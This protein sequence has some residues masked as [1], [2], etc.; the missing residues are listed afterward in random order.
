VGIGGVT[1][2]VSGSRTET[3]TTH[4]SGNFSFA[5]TA[6]GDYTIS[7]A[8]AHYSFSPP[9]T[10]SNLSGDQTADFTG[11]LLNY[12][13]SGQVKSNGVGLNG[14]TLTLGGSQTGATTTDLSGNFY[15][16][17]AAEG[18]YTIIAAKTH[19]SFSPPVTISNLSGD[20]T[21]DFTGTL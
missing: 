21:A 20:Q 18:N 7:A 9:V 1:V 12:V 15:F 13:V 16:A 11:T 5:L 3:T 6:E 19:Y 10:I 8:K 14:V 4:A 2:A 17:L